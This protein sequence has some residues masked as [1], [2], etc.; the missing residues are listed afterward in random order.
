MDLRVDEGFA[1]RIVADRSDAE[2]ALADELAELLR[3][4]PQAVLGLAAGQTPRGLYAEL[5]RRCTA[6]S[7]SFGRATTFNVDELAG[8][9]ASDPLRFDAFM[10]RELFEPAGMAAG[11]THFP[12]PDGDPAKYEEAIRRAGGIDWQLLGLGLN[13]HVA[14]NEPGSD[15]RTRT[16]LVQLAET[17]RRA[18]APAF[19]GLDRT[20]R[21]GMT[22]GI[23]TLLEARA[24]RIMAFGEAKREAVRALVRGPITP[25]V[26][27]SLLRTHADCQLW[28]D[29]PAASALPDRASVSVEW[30][31]VDLGATN[32]RAYALALTGGTV[33]VRFAASGSVVPE[34]F[35]SERGAHRRATAVEQRVEAIVRVIL[36]ALE[37]AGGRAT[38]F[39]VAAPGRKTVDERGILVANQ[40]LPDTQLLQRLERTLRARGAALR[41]P[42]RLHSDALACLWGEL[43]AAEGALSAR[44]SAYLVSCGTGV[45]EALVQRGRTVDVR[46]VPG[47]KPAHA[48]EGTAGAPEDRLS[49]RGLTSAW[50]HMAPG[51]ESF[52]EAAAVAGDTRARQAL[53]DHAR[54]WA[55]WVASRVRT[56]D[57]AGLQLDEVVLA[58]R[59]ARWM[60]PD[61]DPWFAAPFRSTLSASLEPGRAPRVLA[62]RCLAAPA[63]GAVAAE[64]GRVEAERSVAR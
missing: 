19:G 56:A 48:S 10:R 8:L 43:W 23:G 59:A 53:T 32:V 54:R 46:G 60:E 3:A 47:W 44:A 9:T 62:S 1:V 21:E 38:A 14:F 52:A 20:P 22:V 24:L 30:I 58:Q 40:A 2:R 27:A 29:D 17:T 4:R 18:L 13:G 50:R 57:D 37:G 61:L 51:A 39:A 16:R 6:G 34:S 28:I 26:P 42:R 35:A 55:A 12:D 25:D 33:H 36:E 31:G 41:V 5:V 64:T 7:L 63:I 45:G 11:A 15:D 49:A